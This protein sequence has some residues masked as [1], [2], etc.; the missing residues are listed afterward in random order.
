MAILYYWFSKNSAPLNPKN[1]VMPDNIPASPENICWP[2][3][4][5][6]L[7]W[8]TIESMDAFKLFTQRPHFR[9]LENDIEGLREGNAMGHMLSFASLVESTCNARLDD[10]RSM[11]E[12]NLKAL[13]ELE[14]FGFTVRPICSQLEEILEKK[15]AITQLIME[16]ER[17]AKEMDKKI[18]EATFD[19]HRL[20]AACR[21]V[22]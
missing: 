16:K 3:T 12:S 2:F 11:L 10:P 17:L 9:P 8:E 7:M 5:K 13:N 1:Q 20:V 18:R 15:D 19:F 22:H 21:C 14:K 4:K 6:S